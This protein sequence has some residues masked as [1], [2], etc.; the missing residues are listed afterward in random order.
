M[1]NYKLYINGKYV[2]GD[3]GEFISVENPAD[4]QIFARVPD[5]NQADVDRAVAAAR[6]AFP[7]W[8]ALSPEERADYVGKFADYIER[9]KDEVGKTIT[10][11]IG[12]PVKYVYGLQVVSS[13]EQARYYSD[14]A[15]NYSYS[16]KCGNN[17]VR[18]E[19][20]GVIACLTPWNYP[21][22]QETSKIFPAIAAGNCIVLKPSQLA[23]VSAYVLSEAAEE[24][25]L[26][27]GSHK[28]SDRTRRAS[29]NASFKT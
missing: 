22:Y 13:I 11:E 2:N 24:I 14:L 9:H 28:Y 6:A 4:R 27:P 23:P 8:S 12:T 19:P 18:K 16:E 1:D 3:S 20:I 26:P 21:I 5:G 10:S 29:R 15:R 25:G 7:K 17:I